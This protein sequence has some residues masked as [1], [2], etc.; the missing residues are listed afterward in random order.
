MAADLDVDEWDGVGSFAQ[1]AV[2]GSIAGLMEHSVASPFVGDSEKKAG[3]LVNYSLYS[4]GSWAL[5]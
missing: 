3:W 5:Q 4:K 2:S 1:H